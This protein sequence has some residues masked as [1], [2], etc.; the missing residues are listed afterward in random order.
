M[1]DAP[2]SEAATSGPPNNEPAAPRPLPHVVLVR[3]QE[4]GNVGSVARAMANM[5]LES[6]VLVEPAVAIGGTARAFAVGAR[7][8]LEKAQHRVTLEEALAPYS[9]I[10]GTT[11]SRARRPEVP[12]LPP[13]ELPKAL[14]N[15]PPGT[16]TALVFGPESSGLEVSELAL[17]SP[18]ISVPC[19]PA[20]PTLN[21]SQAVLI[22]AYE[23]Y[24]V[25]D[26]SQAAATPFEAE[27]QPAPA[28]AVEGFLGHARE[29]LEEAGFA[30]D[31]SFEAVFLD[32]RRLANRARLSV[33]EV[34]VLRGAC[35]R[36]LRALESRRE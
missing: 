30:R 10:V 4:E 5:G 25:R 13:R 35:R 34:T 32:L 27:D 7:H 1:S 26:P 29:V 22:V 3:P 11:S 17:C 33:R 16:P 20:Q 8:I 9:R 31:D 15:D 24:L 23:L 14:R 18:L 19:A 36:I 21:L 6:L 2:S 12:L 28:G